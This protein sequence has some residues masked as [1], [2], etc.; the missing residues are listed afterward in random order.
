[1][2]VKDVLENIDTDILKK[3]LISIGWKKGA[4]DMAFSRG[5]ISKK[6][7]PDMEKFT[8]VSAKFW[9]MP[10]TYDIKGELIS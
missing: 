9:L 10:D 2:K 4:V 7:A 8:S 6:M 3:R 5:N 1:M